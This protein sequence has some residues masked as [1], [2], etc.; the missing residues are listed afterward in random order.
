MQANSGKTAART[1]ADAEEK[2]QLDNIVLNAMS[3]ASDF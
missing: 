3:L 1:A 2:M